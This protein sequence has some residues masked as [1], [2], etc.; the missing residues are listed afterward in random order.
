MGM[1][2]VVI[3]YC[4]LSYFAFKNKKFTTYKNT[5]II[6]ILI[7]NIL[8]ELFVSRVYDNADILAILIGGV[9]IYIVEK[10][11]FS[12]FKCVKQK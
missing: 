2:V 9:F 5:I 4:T 6:F 11:K 8:Y 3:Y 10:I 7:V 1:S 12:V